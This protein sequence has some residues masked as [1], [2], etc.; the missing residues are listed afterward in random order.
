MTK[1]VN[2]SIII[3]ILIAII[4][5]GSLLV[6]PVA[7]ALEDTRILVECQ[8]FSAGNSSSEVKL[9]LPQNAKVI[10][11]GKT[12]VDANGLSFTEITYGNIAGFVATRNLYQTENTIGNKT[13]KAK[14]T[15]KTIGET[16]A[17]YKYPME[18]DIVA[19]LKDGTHIEKIIDGVEYGDYVEILYNNSR[20]YVKS[21]NVTEGLT[22]YQTIAVVLSVVAFALICIAVGLFIYG[23][24]LKASKE[25]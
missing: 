9:I 4:V 1:I 8:L 22:Y 20:A 2:L 13:V 7:Y 6:G 5:V 21:T 23:K 17:I 19:N 16:V 3:I 11:T 18:S 25:K 24:R 12:A 15:T 10:P 14:I